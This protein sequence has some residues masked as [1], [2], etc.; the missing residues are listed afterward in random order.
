MT[1]M[2][3]T[4]DAKF[5]IKD[6]IHYTVVVATAVLMYSSLKNGQE[7]NE[8]ALRTMT[9]VVRDIQAE[10]KEQRKDGSISSQNL[11]NQVNLNTQQI[12][13]LKQEVDM[14]KNKR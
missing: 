10:N 2:S 8:N 6:I 11:Q 12:L 13:L 9:D 3:W 14:F 4:D 1:H 7:K 5:T